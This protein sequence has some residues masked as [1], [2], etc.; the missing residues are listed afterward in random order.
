MGEW[1]NSR[2]AL[3]ARKNH[4]TYA[5]GQIIRCPYRCLQAVLLPIIWEHSIT[6]DFA[7]ID[8]NST[9]NSTSYYTIRFNNNSLKR[10]ENPCVGGSIPPLATALQSIISIVN[11][12]K[13]QLK[14]ASYLS[15]TRF[16]KPYFGLSTCLQVLH[17]F[18]K[19]RPYHPLR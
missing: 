17:Q 18:Y 1:K 13:S 6:M 11:P 3:T 4:Y 10:T 16:Y 15:S 7:L 14:Q 5:R 9:I 12:Y 19:I 2:L 8:C